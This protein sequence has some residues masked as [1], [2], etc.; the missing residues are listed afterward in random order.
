[1]L[2]SRLMLVAAGVFL[3]AG[4]QTQSIVETRNKATVRRYLKE[5]VNNTSGDYS[6]AYEVISPDFTLYIGGKPSEEKGVDVFTNV[7][8]FTKSFSKLTLVDDEMIAEGN[9]V[10]VRWYDEVVHDRGVFLGY[11][12][13]PDDTD[14]I[15]HGMSFYK[16]DDNGLISEAHI[17]DDRVEVLEMRRRANEQ[18]DVE[19]RNLETFHRYWKEIVNHGDFSKHHEII[20][21]NFTGYFPGKPVGLKGVDFLKKSKQQRDRAFSKIELFEDQL[22]AD[23]NSIAV[24]WHAVALHD[25]GSIFDYGPDGNEIV[26]Q[27]M[28]FYRC[29]ENGLIAEAH[30]VH[31]LFHVLELREQ[32]SGEDDLLT[33]MDEV[34]R[35][36]AERAMK[37]AD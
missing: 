15:W 36:R 9:T 31:N 2:E 16:F 24:R 34:P 35:S 6:K 8:E 4:C 32:S 29:D 11:E 26:W 28:N 27:G 21:P 13:I 22:I 7:A 3:L 14:M 20:S 37:Q 1:M 30:V 17:V 10:A 5:V 12:V 23:G 19:T 18:G 25:R 33:N